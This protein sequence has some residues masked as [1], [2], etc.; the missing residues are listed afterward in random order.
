[1]PENA[2][3]RLESPDPGFRLT[4]EQRASVAPGFDMDALERLL[5]AVHPELRMPIL[6]DF[7]PQPPDV[8]LGPMK[9]EDPVLQALLNEVWAPRWDAVPDDR[10]DD[11]EMSRYPGHRIAKARRA[12]Q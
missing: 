2:S 5:A 8:F 1:M 9:F 10:L 3:A 11:P 6:S 7:Q 12:V 4:A